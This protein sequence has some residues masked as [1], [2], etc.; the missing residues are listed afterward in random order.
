MA[1]PSAA[2]S[3]AGRMLCGGPFAR[4][5]LLC[6]AK[7]FVIDVAQLW[8]QFVQSFPLPAPISVICVLLSRFEVVG[9]T[10]EIFRAGVI[11]VGPYRRLVPIRS[12][13]SFFKFGKARMR[14]HSHQRCAPAPIG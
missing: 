5:A 6:A 11:D 8:K 10:L 12:P 4:V 2:S 7:N 14:N 3:F 9:E 1:N 13:G